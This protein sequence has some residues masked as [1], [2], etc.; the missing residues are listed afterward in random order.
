MTSPRPSRR[1]SLPSLDGTTVALRI[2]SRSRQCPRR[3]WDC[4]VRLPRARR[5]AHSSG[6]ARGGGRIS[7]VSEEPRVC[8]CR[9]P[10]PRWDSRT[11]P[12]GWESVAPAL[13]ST[14]APY[15]VA[16]EARHPASALAVYASQRRLPVRHARLASGRWPDATGRAWLPAR[17]QRKVSAQIP[18]ITSPFLELRGTRSDPVNRQIRSLFV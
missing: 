10:R 6:N 3:A 5:G 2:R 14:K 1:A 9:V 16:F 12:S 11:R 13:T 8:L 18:F 15:K 17:F 7:H 4:V